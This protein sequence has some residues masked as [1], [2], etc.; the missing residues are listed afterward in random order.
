[1]AQQ[2]EIIRISCTRPGLRR[3]GMRHPAG[4]VDHPAGSFSKVQLA[5]LAAEPAIT[6]ERLTLEAEP[7]S[8]TNT[9]G[10]SGTA[11]EASSTDVGTQVDQ[12]TGQADVGTQSAAQSSADPGLSADQGGATT[13]EGGADDDEAPSSTGEPAAP[14]PAGRK[15]AGKKA[16][17]KGAGKS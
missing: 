11:R 14:K 4:P 12:D 13:A 1:M 8:D 3:G 5:Q 7:K 16:A 6:L 15:P 2:K 10:R 9:Q 17:A